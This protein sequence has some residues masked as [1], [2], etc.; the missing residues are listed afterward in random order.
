MINALNAYDNPRN[1]PELGGEYYNAWAWALDVGFMYKLRIIEFLK[2]FNIGIML[3][4]VSGRM[5]RF[6]TGVEEPIYFTSTIALSM[7]TTELIEKEITSFS[8]DWDAVNDPG[9]LENE[10]NRLKF[11]FEQWML[12]NHFAVRGGLIYFMYPGPWRFSMGVSARYW[13]GID[14]AYVRGIPFDQKSE[15]EEESH[16]VSVYWMWGHTKR[17]LPT[18]DVFAAVEPIAFAP[19]NG[20][21]GW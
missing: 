3:R 18:P 16:W 17:K 21:T 10:K 6:K 9:V 13:M 20:E 8:I 2:D 12:D 4:D 5:K 15:E 11:G 19:K 7:R 14:Y 1:E